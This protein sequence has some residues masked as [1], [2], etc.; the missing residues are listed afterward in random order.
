MTDEGKFLEVIP[1]EGNGYAPLLFS[2]GWQVA[3]L[4]WEPA[5]DLGS[6][7]EIER[8]AQTD[9]VF[10]LW[11]GHASLYVR[12]DHGIQLEDLRPG[13][14]YNVTAGTW[15]NL[16]ATRDV[17]LWIVENRDTHLYD[18]EIGKLEPP[19]KAQLLAQFPEWARKAALDE[20]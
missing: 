10:G 4:N 20:R 14:I 3:I 12:T 18:S 17:S 16:I 13:V 6:L 2:A 9:E 7:G 8:H 11:H 15:H 5:I 19:E 1:Y